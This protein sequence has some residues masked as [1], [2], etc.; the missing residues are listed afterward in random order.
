M[1]CERNTLLVERKI[2]LNE[3]KKPLNAFKQLI[4]TLLNFVARRGIASIVVG[5]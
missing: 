1:E 2:I 3:R 5:L 4:S